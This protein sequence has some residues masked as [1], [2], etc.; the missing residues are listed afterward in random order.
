MSELKILLN[1]INNNQTTVIPPSQ[2]ITK[3][4]DSGDEDNNYNNNENFTHTV[5]FTNGKTLNLVYNIEARWDYLKIYKNDVNG[6]L[7]GTYDS[8][9]DITIDISDLTG[10]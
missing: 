1:A 8:T 2:L 7:I 5:T 6:E 10:L 9:G 3:I 4:I